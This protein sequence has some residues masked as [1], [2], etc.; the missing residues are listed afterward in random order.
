MAVIPRS[1]RAA[2]DVVAMTVLEA[3]VMPVPVE[4]FTTD[5]VAPATTD[6]AGLATADLEVVAKAV[7]QAAHRVH[8]ISICVPVEAEVWP[9]FV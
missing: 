3:L 5:L 1:N 7:R 9:L 6:L 8:V 4:V 2:A